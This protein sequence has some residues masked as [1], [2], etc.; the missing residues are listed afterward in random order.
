[1]YNQVNQVKFSVIVSNSSCVWFNV[2]FIFS[3]Q[4]LSTEFKSPVANA[5]SNSVGVVPE[6]SNNLNELL[7]FEFSFLKS[8]AYFKMHID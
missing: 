5:T 1:M 8:W 4:A 7:L 3:G 2:N 6:Y